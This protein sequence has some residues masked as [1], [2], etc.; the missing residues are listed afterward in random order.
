MEDRALTTLHVCLQHQLS[1][2][3]QVRKPDQSRFHQLI[4]GPATAGAGGVG[5]RKASP[6]S[7]VLHLL[8]GSQ[9]YSDSLPAQLVS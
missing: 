5:A 9:P 1:V 6:P 7:L 3:L 4:P 2:S 8:T